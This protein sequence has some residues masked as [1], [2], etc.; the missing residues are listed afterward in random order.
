MGE[1]AYVVGWGRVVGQARGTADVDKC[2]GLRIVHLCQS[3]RLGFGP[4]M[5]ISDSFVQDASR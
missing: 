4:A 5:L 2:D 1:V 3:G